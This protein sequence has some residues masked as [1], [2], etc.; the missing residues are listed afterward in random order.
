MQVLYD[1][2]NFVVVHVDM[3]APPV[4]FMGFSEALLV[5]E[6]ISGD[7]LGIPPP[8]DF[9]FEIVDKRCNRG[10]FLHTDWAK[11]F[12][13]KIKEWRVTTPT[14]DEIEACLEGYAQ[15]AQLPMVLQ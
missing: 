1:S 6:F 9:A 10:V 5:K 15:L 14:Q 12:Q 7:D 13:F 8:Q 3:E 4:E 11:A 2:E